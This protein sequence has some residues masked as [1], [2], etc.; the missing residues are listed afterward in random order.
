MV[1]QIVKNP[2]AM[3]QTQVWSLGQEDPLE[4]EMQPTPVFLSGEF[5]GWRILEGYSPWGRKEPLRHHW[6]TNTFPFTCLILN[7]EWLHFIVYNGWARRALDI[8]CHTSHFVLRM[9][10]LRPRGAVHALEIKFPD[11]HPDA[12]PFEC[13]EPTLPTWQDMSSFGRN[14]EIQC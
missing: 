10:K 13:Q 5:H 6:V 7:K 2:P 11:A 4:K 1:A 12:L 9:G 14:L 8:L 3:L